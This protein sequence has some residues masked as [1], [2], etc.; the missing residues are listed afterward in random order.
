MENSRSPHSI[1]RV[2][3]RGSSA[4]SAAAQLLDDLR[5]AFR[6]RSDALLVV[7]PQAEDLHD[8]LALEDLIDQAMLDIDA[9]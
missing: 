2:A 8:P 7:G 1:V 3:T 4:C 9:A 6:T 5:K